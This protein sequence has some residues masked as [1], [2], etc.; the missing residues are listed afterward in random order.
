[1][2]KEEVIVVRKTSDYS[3]F[4]VMKGNRIVSRNRVEK[5][6]A[7]ITKV[8]Y[9]INPIIVNERMEVIDGQGR[10]NALKE[11][12]FPVYYLVVPG[13]GIR[14][15]ISMNINQEKWTYMDYIRSFADRDLEDYVTLK[16][17]IDKYAPGVPLRMIIA[18]L[19]GNRTY[20][21]NKTLCEGDFRICR[22]N[23]EDTLD[24]LSQY[25][26]FKSGISGSWENLIKVLTWV[27]DSK[28]LDETLMY[29]QF[30]KYGIRTIG[31]IGDTNDALDG[32][33]Q[34]YNYRKKKHVYF[35]QA[36]YEDME[37]AVP[38]KSFIHRN[39]R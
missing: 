36:Y 11:L 3:M 4:K 35:R 32:L 31:G 6:I 26:E 22:W 29:E 21:N 23:W 13:I 18:I 14:E 5:I 20:I 15:C 33:E 16:K 12:G 27:Y 28:M 9:V 10:L 37:A 19:S 34:V 24:Y 8:G 2:G 39:E 1:M 30:R 7:S 38:R 17:A 25:A